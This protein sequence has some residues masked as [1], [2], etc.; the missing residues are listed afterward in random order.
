MDKYGKIVIFLTLVTASL[1][2][3]GD[4]AYAKYRVSGHR[5]SSVLQAVN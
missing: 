4:I 2:I 5:L 3:V 1:V